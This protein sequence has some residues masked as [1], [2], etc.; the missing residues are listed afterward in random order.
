MYEK[1]SELV[2]DNVIITHANIK[3]YSKIIFSNKYQNIIFPYIN[4]RL[5]RNS[6]MKIC[7]LAGLYPEEVTRFTFYKEI[8][9][10]SNESFYKNEESNISLTSDLST[11]VETSPLGKTKE[12]DNDISNKKI[13]ILMFKTSKTRILLE[14]IYRYIY[15]IYLLCAIIRMISLYSVYIGYNEEEMSAYKVLSILLTFLLVNISVYGLCQMRNW[16]VIHL[17]ILS[18]LII[19]TIIITFITCY[20]PMNHDFDQRIIDEYTFRHYFFFYLLIIL[21]IIGVIV[22]YNIY[23]QFKSFIDETNNISTRLILES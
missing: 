14:K 3:Q 15:S 4:I 9:N 10:K 7:S 21:L 18:L 23:K 19:F 22:N 11:L 5:L 1:N 17:K 20:V 2:E 16:Y 12:Q 13:E 8:N 6:F